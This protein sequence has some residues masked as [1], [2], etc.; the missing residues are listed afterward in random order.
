VVDC[1]R[2]RM[3]NLG[4]GRTLDALEASMKN[5]EYDRSW[6]QVRLDLKGTDPATYRAACQLL[7]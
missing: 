3:R 5:R 2:P 7:R 6:Y 1:T 4:E